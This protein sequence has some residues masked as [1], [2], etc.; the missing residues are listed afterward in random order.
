MLNCVISSQ[1]KDFIFP[2]RS[3]WTLITLHV[4]QFVIPNH[5]ITKFQPVLTARREKSILAPGVRR[6]LRTLWP[7]LMWVSWTNGD[8][9]RSVTGITGF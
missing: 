9:L 2:H 8:Q 6:F 1:K 4:G 3:V 5:A 7:M